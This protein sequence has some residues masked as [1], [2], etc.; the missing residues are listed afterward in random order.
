MLGLVLEPQPVTKR[1]MMLDALETS[2]LPHGSEDLGLLK[3]QVRTSLYSN[4]TVATL[5]TG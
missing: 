5:T 3:E 1:H 4:E 2:M